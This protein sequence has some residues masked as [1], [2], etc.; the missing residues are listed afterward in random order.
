MKKSLVGIIVAVVIIS[1]YGAVATSL[2]NQD[3]AEK[4]DTVVFSSVTLSESQEYTTVDLSEATSYLTTQGSYVVPVVTQ[5]VYV[6]IY[7]KNNGCCGQF[8]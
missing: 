4:T 7:D 1:G 2:T 3:S 5:G 6:S 8:F